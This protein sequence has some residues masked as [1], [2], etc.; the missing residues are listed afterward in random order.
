MTDIGTF[1]NAQIMQ[2]IKM[3]HLSIPAL[4]FLFVVNMPEHTEWDA[5]KNGILPIHCGII[6]RE[7]SHVSVKCTLLICHVWILSTIYGHL[8][9]V[10]DVTVVVVII[11]LRNK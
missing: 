1:H 5:N 3:Q 7:I 11:Q 8:V 2:P 9:F 6:S 10:A 4:G